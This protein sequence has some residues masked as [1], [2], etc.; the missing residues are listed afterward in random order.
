M[1]REAILAQTLVDLADTLV[2]DFDVVD[3]LTLLAD[4]CVSVL[5]ASAAGIML[6]GADGRLHPIAASSEAMHLLE[7]FESQAQEGPCLDCY[8]TGTAVAAPD[9]TGDT[10]WPGFSTRAVE[11]GFLSAT[12]LPMRRRGTI[13]GALNF[14]RSVTGPINDSDFAAAQALADIAT[15][16]LMQHRIALE[17][18]MLNEQLET[19][20]H[21]RIGIEQAKGMIVERFQIDLEEAFERLRSY[22]RSH[23]IGISQVAGDIASGELPIGDLYEQKDTR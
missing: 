18:Q 14:F 10:P 9:L 2:D 16:A 21:S 11:A 19:A 12:A 13:I 8:L 15:I 3:V 22:A 5:D 6:A 7:L 17:A 20:L 23:R 1:T 4:R